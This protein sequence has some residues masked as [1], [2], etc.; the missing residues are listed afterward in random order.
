MTSSCSLETQ[1]QCCYIESGQKWVNLTFLLQSVYCTLKD[2]GKHHCLKS[3]GQ[4]APSNHWR[5]LKQSEVINVITKLDPSSWESS[6][7]NSIS[8]VSIHVGLRFLSFL[9]SQTLGFK[10][11]AL[12][13]S[14][15]DTICPFL[16]LLEI[17]IFCE[18]STQS[19]FL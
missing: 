13:N 14:L 16:I 5:V 11:S 19:V 7:S 9:Q 2:K 12:S 17:F 15:L 6:Y 4:L 3:N 1:P 10:L 18:A 8:F